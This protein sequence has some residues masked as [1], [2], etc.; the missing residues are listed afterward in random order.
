MPSA[1][2][3]PGR[4]ID[5]IGV[6]LG[7]FLAVLFWSLA[8]MAHAL[9]RWIP[10]EAKVDD[11][12]APVV[13]GAGNWLVMIP[14]TVVGFSIA[15]FALGFAEGGNFPAAV[16]AVSL[17]FPKKERALA[18]GIFNAGTNVG[19]L[20]AALLV[21]WLTITF[22]WPMAFLMTG[23]LGF[24]WLAAWGRLYQDP[25]KHPRLSPVELAHIR[26]DPPDPVVKIRWLALLRYR[27]TWALGAWRERSA[28]CSAPNSPAMSS[29]GRAVYTA[30]FG[31]AATAYLVNLAIIHALHP[32][33]EPMLWNGA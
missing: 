3:G 27:Q 21:P 8:A 33:L 13:H 16:K 18:T 11:W 19:I 15:R 25:E 7:Y 1:T 10:P 14:L 17:W 24:A 31:I 5:R 6:R 20:I 22:G 28:A 30:L 4:L 26:S 12:A 29:S 2:E 9:T 32:R 23:V